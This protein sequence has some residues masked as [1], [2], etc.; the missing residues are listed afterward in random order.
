[1]KSEFV[2]SCEPEDV[3]K[4]ISECFLIDEGYNTARTGRCVAPDAATRFVEA[5]R[6]DNFDVHD[7]RGFDGSI[8]AFNSKKNLYVY[9]DT[10]N[11]FTDVYVKNGAV[12]SIVEFFHKY[13]EYFEYKDPEVVSVRYY[14]KSVFGSNSKHISVP[15][16]DI[17]H[18]IPEL[19]PDYD[20]EKLT[21]EFIASNSNILLLYGKPGVGKTQFLRY[22]M[23]RGEFE[24]ITYVKDAALLNS[25]D[26][27]AEMAD[28]ESDLMVF[29]DMDDALRPRK[30]RKTKGDDVVMD[31]RTFM[32]N[33]L[34][35]T[36]GIFEK[37]TKIIIT[38]NQPITQIDAA[39]IRPGRCF[40][41]LTLNPLTYDEACDLWVGV[42]KGNKEQFV[43]LYG[44][45]DTV[46]QASLMSDYERMQH[47]FIER[48][49]IKRGDNTYNLEKKMR[50]GGITVC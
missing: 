43:Q 12:A 13:Q 36:D 33:V 42:L 40:D 48:S 27:W 19:Y 41:F 9:A 25:G 22:V 17:Q 4:A 29:D 18:T 2:I 21:E 46:T 24:D 37:K 8:T 10:R 50:D 5:L 31:N 28:T 11:G 49:Y 35:F 23:K 45:Q 30:A 7:L 32:N 15:K 3:G 39:V 44:G 16:E 14:F 6:F 47:S 1:M 26:F 20:V 34:S 38:T